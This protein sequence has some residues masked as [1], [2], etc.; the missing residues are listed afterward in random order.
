MEK[1]S[2]LIM[3]SKSPLFK[4]IVKGHVSDVAQILSTIKINPNNIVDTFNKQN[5]YF[6]TALI[7]EDIPAL[8][9][10]KYFKLKGINPLRKDKNQQ[11]CLFYACREGKKSCCNYLINKCKLNIN[12]KDIFGQT[13]IFYCIRGNKLNTTKLML[14]LGADINVQDIFG[15]TCLFYAIKESYNDLVELLIWAGAKIEVVDKSGRTPYMFAKSNGY[16][17]IC[18]IL[19]KNGA[20]DYDNKI[21]YRSPFCKIDEK[22]GV[23]ILHN[24][25]N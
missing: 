7:K 20:K 17:D 25:N 21:G 3:S 1:N 19:A 18:D 23:F 8:K 4:A 22:K 11:T 2:Q 10:I 14:K 16:D 6:Y 9:L 12:D 15:Q 24:I 13:P 5:V